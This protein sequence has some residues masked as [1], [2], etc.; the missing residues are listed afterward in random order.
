MSYSSYSEY[1]TNDKEYKQLYLKDSHV[2][3]TIYATSIY[4]N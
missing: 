3:I 2:T 1:G 4:Q